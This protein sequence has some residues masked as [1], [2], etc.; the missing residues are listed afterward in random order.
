MRRWGASRRSGTPHFSTTA[1]QAY[2]IPPAMPIGACCSSMRISFISYFIVLS[3]DRVLPTKQ[4]Q[5]VQGT[6]S[7][8][9]IGASSLAQRFWISRSGIMM[10][11]DFD[12]IAGP[13]TACWVL[14]LF[15]GLWP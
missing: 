10:F 6:V 14:A 2:L 7:R 1:H 12:T 13:C 4:E 8:L 5:A 11:L 15:T 9:G 3:V